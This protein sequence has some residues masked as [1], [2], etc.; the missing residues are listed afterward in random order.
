MAV[1]KLRMRILEEGGPAYIIAARAGISPSRVSE[2]TLGRRR[3][4]PH[5]VVAL[6]RVLK[7]NPDELLGFEPETVEPVYTASVE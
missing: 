1:S 4:P 7:C 3:I 6:C 2:Y 5:H